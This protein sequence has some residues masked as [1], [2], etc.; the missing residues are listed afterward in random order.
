MRKL[1]FKFFFAYALLISCSIYAQ[2]SME[3][4]IFTNDV[5][6]VQ[7]YPPND[8]LGDPFLVLDDDSRKLL[9][10]F[11][12]FG[13]EYMEYEYTL[14][15]CDADWVPTDMLPNEYIDGYTEDYITEYEFSVNTKQSYIHYSLEFPKDNMTLTKSGNYILK[16]YL[17]DDSENPVFTKRIMVYDPIAKIGGTISR[18]SNPSRGMQDQEIVFKVNISSVRSHFPAKEIR[19]FI[20][21]NNRW[22]NMIK[23]L[24]PLSITNGIMDYNL[25]DK[26]I[27]DGLNTFR[28]FDFTSMRYNSEY[29][30]MIDASGDIDQVYLLTEEPRRFEQYIEKTDFHGAYYIETKDWENSN[31]EAEYSNVNFTFKYNVPLTDGDVYVFGELSNWNMTDYNKMTYNY[32]KRAYEGSLFLKQ[33]FYSYLYAFLPRDTKVADISFFEGSHYQTKNLYYVFVYYRA[34]GTIYDQLVGLSLINEY[35]F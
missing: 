22:D 29:V 13:S 7:V 34:P 32:E 35:D 31:I 4:K 10:S 15:H 6:S 5:E 17:E 12:L 14:I 33:G 30:D 9:L 16:V 27:F 23:D 2:D 19:V 20:T 24:Q 1:V 8:P 21:Q 26:N 3:N 18:S 25:Q 11:D 28:Y